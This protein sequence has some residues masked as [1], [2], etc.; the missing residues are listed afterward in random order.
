MKVAKF[1]D[2]LV[3]G[4][5]QIHQNKNNIAPIHWSESSD[6]ILIRNESQT[7]NILD[8]FF[9]IKKL[10]SFIRQLNIYGFYKTKRAD[11]IE[12]KNKH[13]KRNNRENLFKIKRRSCRI[14]QEKNCG[15]KNIDIENLKKRHEELR[16]E[17]A[18]KEEKLKNL[19][20]EGMKKL[21]E[22]FKEILNQLKLKTGVILDKNQPNSNLDIFESRDEMDSL[23]L[24]PNKRGEIV[25][26]LSDR[27][28]ISAHKSC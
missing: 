4:L 24:S 10:S 6:S 16:R 5:E 8:E 17:K 12:Y 2:T 11:C 20:I 19:K 23:I 18:E 9:K 21:K 13:F 22:Q 14:A 28:R 15:G 1:I 25:S 26:L 7:S 27:D 3:N